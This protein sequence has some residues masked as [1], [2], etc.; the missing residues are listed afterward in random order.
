[1]R[2]IGRSYRGKIEQGKKKGR[3]ERKKRK[4]EEILKVKERKMVGG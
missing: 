1:M 4:R 3:R 2:D